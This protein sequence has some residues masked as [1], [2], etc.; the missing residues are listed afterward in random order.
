MFNKIYIWFDRTISQ[1]VKKMDTSR[2]VTF[3]ANADY[4]EEKAVRF[5]IHES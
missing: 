2:L 1:F 5:M 3:V 4:Q